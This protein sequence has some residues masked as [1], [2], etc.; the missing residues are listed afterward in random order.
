[1]PQ[2][3]KAF[4]LVEIL[5]VVSIIASISSV[6]LVGL[7]AA[8]ASG[9]DSARQSSALQVRNALAL[10][11]T[12][13]GGVPAATASTPGCQAKISAGVTS[14]VCKQSLGTSLQAGVLAPL[15]PKYIS[16]IAVDMVNTNGLEYSYI[17]APADPTLTASNGGTPTTPTASFNYVSELKSIDPVNN[18][19]VVSTPIGEPNYSSYAL[20]GYP[21]GSLIASPSIT[22]FTG[23]SSLTTIVNG[24]WS[25]GVL[26]P[27]S[28]V[29]T[30]S[31]DWG[32]ST[33]DS[34][35]SSGTSLNVSHTY[36]LP[37]YYTVTV[38]VTGTGLPVSSQLNVSVSLPP[39]Q[40]LSI[41]KSGSGTGLV[42]SSPLGIS[43]GSTCS[44]NRTY[45]S[46][47][48]LTAHPDSGSTFAGWS[49]ACS[50]TGTCTVVMS[51][52][53]SVTA[54][55][56]LSTPAPIVDLWVGQGSF[57]NLG[58][59]ASNNTVNTGGTPLW[60]LMTTQWLNS[61][62]TSCSLALPAFAMFWGS[63]GDATNGW[64][65]IYVN[66]FNNSI[67]LT[68]NCTGP[69]GSGS[70]SVTLVP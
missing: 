21:S 40:V 13:H 55:F 1:M 36:A 49:G 6:V 63:G 4:T 31:I 59:N 65:S 45:G 34:L 44:A 58:R 22:S 33:T 60:G 17:S 30:Y 25:I 29:L 16:Q 15:V 67:P 35:T 2:T 66:G 41:S 52:A 27:G 38:T 46:T 24:T 19:V 14:Y 10:Y 7:K 37:N 9:R 50:G 56:V 69:G 54:T 26:N 32:D 5:V 68:L 11:A 64:E 12:D 51:A 48:I 3:T 8:Q 18:P 61:N 47:N 39:S 62:A 42:S 20:T 70:D 28:V 57:T 23:P 43:C 53:Q